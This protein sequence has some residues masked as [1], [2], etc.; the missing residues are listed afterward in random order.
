M[1]RRSEPSTPYLHA[2]PSA[3]VATDGNSDFRLFQHFSPVK[4]DARPGVSEDPA[5]LSNIEA[6]V[7]DQVA[8]EGVPEIVE[9]AR[10]RRRLR[11]EGWG[12]R[13]VADVVQ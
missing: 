13:L 9:S 1:R 6:E 2:L 12:N 7:D 8:R 5:D 4:R 10:H 3:T 11:E